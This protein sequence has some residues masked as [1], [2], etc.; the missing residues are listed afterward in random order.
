MSNDVGVPEYF[1]DVVSAIV[2]ATALGR[3]NPRVFTES[4]QG[5]GYQITRIDPADLDALET[6]TMPA[7]REYT[8]AAEPAT[9][10]TCKWWNFKNYSAQF[11]FAPCLNDV[12]HDS[13]V[14]TTYAGFGCNQHEPREGGRTR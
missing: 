10:S 9:C 11:H 3:V 7:K 1:S 4:L 8:I 6:I 5:S 12:A 14:D 13:G 2:L